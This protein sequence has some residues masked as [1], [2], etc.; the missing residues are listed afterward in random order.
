MKITRAER[1]IKVIE[2]NYSNKNLDVNW[3]GKIITR[4]TFIGKAWKK[5]RNILGKVDKEVDRKIINSF[6]TFDPSCKNYQALKLD[7]IKCRPSLI[8]SGLIKTESP[9]EALRSV[10]SSQLINLGA[11][12]QDRKGFMDHHWQAPAAILSYSDAILPKELIPKLMKEK[13][14]RALGVKYEKGDKITNME[15]ALHTFLNPIGRIEMIGDLAWKGPGGVYGKPFG[16]NQGRQVV[17]SALVQPDFENTQVLMKIA[18][19]TDQ[20]VQGKALAAN[21]KFPDQNEAWKGPDGDSRQALYDNDLQK[22]MI[23]HLTTDHRLP[24]KSTAMEWDQGVAFLE[25]LINPGITKDQIAQ[26]LKNKAVN[27]N[28]RIISLEVMFHVFL[29]QAKNELRV[30][31][32][33]LPQGYVYSMDPPSIF[34]NAIG[35]PQDSGRVFNR[36]QALAFMCVNK[37]TPL[38][39]MKVCAFSTYA[40]VEMVKQLQRALPGK[41]VVSKDTLF[42]GKPEDNTYLGETLAKGAALVLHNNSDAFGQNIE[43]EGSSSLDG[44]VGSFSSAYKIVERDRTDYLVTRQKGVYQPLRKE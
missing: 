17:L 9:T 26:Q 25:A 24:A 38:K 29:E 23:Y 44:V 13:K 33:E 40:D 35:S 6:K 37:E 3:Q 43:T 36:L 1:N 20:E 32:A 16:N 10:N 22:H 41:T 2:Q 7:L 11:D 15:G 14:D 34:L 30:L 21:Y 4:E 39:N 19:L 8:K 28:G 27:L 31:E 12:I 18:E 42:K 5:M